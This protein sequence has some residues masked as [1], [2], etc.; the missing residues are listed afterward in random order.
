MQRSLIFYV[1]ATEEIAGDDV[2][3]GGFGVGS[4]CG[5]VA[6]AT[7]ETTALYHDVDVG[8]HNEFDTTAEGMDVYFLVLG[9]HSLAQVHANATT[10]SIEART[11][12]R[13]AVIDVLVATIVYRATD[14]L[15][16]LADG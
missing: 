1:N 3:G 11:M 8:G 9:N 2:E 6:D 12:E 15:A 10:E 14:A 13:L 5:M 7:Y 4:M 16:V